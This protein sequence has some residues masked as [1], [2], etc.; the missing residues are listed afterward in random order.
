MAYTRRTTAATATRAYGAKAPLREVGPGTTD[1]RLDRLTLEILKRMEAE[2][3][4]YSV[5]QLLSGL[6]KC[7]QV[8]LI[9]QRLR[10]Q[11]YSADVGSSVRKYASNFQATNASGRG[12]GG[13][14][15]S[16]RTSG[17]YDSD[18]D[19]IIDLVASDDDE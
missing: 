16:A 17:A 11:G 5:P 7:L 6:H 10:S 3:D 19:N 14:R 8:Q 2:L 15:R 18:L 13:S 12:K 4:R 9:M 1:Q